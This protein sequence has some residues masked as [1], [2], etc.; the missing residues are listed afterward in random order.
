[1]CIQINA[2]NRKS[3]VLYTK[4]KTLKHHSCFIET[5]F[6]YCSLIWMNINNTGMKNT[7]NVQKRVL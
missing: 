2:L 5:N 3:K 6:N 4:I 7:E 1:M